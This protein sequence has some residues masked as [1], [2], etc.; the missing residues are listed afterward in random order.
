MSPIKPRNE[1]KL[2]DG[3]VSLLRAAD[4]LGVSRQKVSRLLK[5][6]VLTGERFE[7]DERVVL[8]DMEELK[9]L[10]EKSSNGRGH[11]NR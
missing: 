11:R 8:I 9:A 3:K 6:G 4:Y 1:P 10:K 7:L 2:P 5:K